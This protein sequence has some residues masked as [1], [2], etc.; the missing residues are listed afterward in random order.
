MK[1]ARC[2][3]EDSH[4]VAEKYDSHLQ[5]AILGRSV[6]VDTKER[7]KTEF[8]SANRKMLHLSWDA[9][10]SLEVPQIAVCNG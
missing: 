5:P 1:L 6:Y 7:A 3:D 9:M 8:M 10:R 4:V 2:R